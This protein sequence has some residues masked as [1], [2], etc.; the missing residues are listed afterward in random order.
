M[1]YSGGSMGI[2]IGSGLGTAIIGWVLFYGGYVGGGGTQSNAA[3]LSIQ[4]LFIYIPMAITVFLIIL[5]LFYRLDK[6]YPR[7]ISDLKARSAN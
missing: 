6:I 7:I 4:S 1:V 5:M 3:L 2:K